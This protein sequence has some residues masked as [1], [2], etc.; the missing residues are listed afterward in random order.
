MEH[1]LHT[2]KTSNHKGLV[3]TIYAIPFA[4]ITAFPATVSGTFTLVATKFFKKIQITAGTGKLVTQS[5]G[6][7][8][9]QMSNETTLDL[10]RAVVDAEAFTWLDA[11][12]N[13]ELVFV[14]PNRNGVQVIMGDALQG[15]YLSAGTIDSGD[16]AATEAGLT[17]Q[18]KHEGPK[19]MVWTGTA[20]LA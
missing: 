14:V 11:N 19:P 1:L 20:P 17:V 5:V 7:G 13:E 8:P 4:D 3:E 18:F 6:E 2:T 10:K 15:C 16:K 9:R 12:Q